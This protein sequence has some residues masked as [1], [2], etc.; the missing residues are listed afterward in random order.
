MSAHDIAIRLR[1]VSKHYM[2][3]AEP[4]DRLKQS[5]IPRFQ[6][7]AGQPPKQYYR[8]FAALSSVSF[9]IR[10]GETV[11]IVGRNGSGKSTLL[12]LV[13]GTLDPTTGTVE[14]NGR[15]AALLELGSGFNPEYTGRENVY[16]NGAILGISRKDLDCRF[17]DIARFAD[18][19][20]FIDQP[21]K[22]YS[23][24]MVVRL[25]FATAINVDPDVL[26][27]DEALAV[28][29]E[30]F[31]RKCYARIEDIKD[32]GGTILFVSHSTQT[33]VQLC[34][35]AMLFD[36]GE[37]LLDG[38]PKIVTNQYQR[39]LNLPR[40]ETPPIREEIRAMGTDAADRAREGGPG[41]EAANAKS[42]EIA[43]GQLGQGWLDPS[44]VSLTT[45]SYEGSQARIHDVHFTTLSGEPVNVLVKGNRYRYEY[46]A[47]FFTD[48]RDVSF[49]MLFKSVTGIELAGA[50]N[51]RIRGRR[52]ARVGRGDSFVASFEFPCTLLPGVYFTSAGIMATVGDERRF[53]H[54]L[55]DVITFRVID[56]SETVDYGFFGLGCEVTVHRQT[57]LRSESVGSSGD[58]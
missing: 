51:D 18:I 11:G 16:L 20:D 53:L 43:L 58:R 42:E 17:D 41:L 5:I 31:Q 23:S 49:G 54:R 48:A 36:S 44:L 2:M 57:G 19:G 26:V 46:R 30:A 24:G 38:G 1:G 7:L 33:I 3:Y 25:A 14:V 40:E 55:L 47:D 34:S 56:N 13:C 39:L 6:R 10:R 15:I 12:Q 27:V 50:N 21:L 32:K 52:L 22:T 35:R 28:G 8:D 29:D 4:K 37:L 9:D 45:V